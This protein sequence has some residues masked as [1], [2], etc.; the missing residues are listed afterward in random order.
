MIAKYLYTLL[1]CSS[2]FKNTKQKT[3]KKKYPFGQLSE[4]IHSQI[5][6]LPI[7][8][9]RESESHSKVMLSDAQ[10]ELK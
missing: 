10:D 7:P 4:Y 6:E 3:N 2:I 8:A 1:N 9:I 5:W